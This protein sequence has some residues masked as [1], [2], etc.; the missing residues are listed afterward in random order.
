M[1]LREYFEQRKD[2]KIAYEVYDSSEKIKIM[3]GN[4]KLFLALLGDYFLDR[5]IIVE[6]YVISIK[7]E[8]LCKR[9]IIDCEVVSD[10]IMG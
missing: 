10:D 7:D 6:Y 1:K 2:E 4:P 9:I 8:N 3:E 5:V